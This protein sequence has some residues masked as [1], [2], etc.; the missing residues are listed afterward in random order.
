[1][2]AAQAVPDRV[3]KL[4]MPGMLSEE[5]SAPLWVP[6]CSHPSDFPPGERPDDC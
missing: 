6:C 1:M 5:P 3:T 2:G 4:G